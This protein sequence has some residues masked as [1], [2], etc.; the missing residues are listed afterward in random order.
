MDAFIGVGFDMAAALGM[1]V[2]QGRDQSVRNNKE[3][4]CLIGL[5]LMGVTVVECHCLVQHGQ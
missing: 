2:Q 3:P 4:L 1:E 5:L